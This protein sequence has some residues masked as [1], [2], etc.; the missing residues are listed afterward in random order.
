MKGKHPINKTSVGF[1]LWNQTHKNTKDLKIK[2]I[3]TGPEIT[4]LR[5]KLKEKLKE[6]PSH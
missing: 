1:L 3:I 2:N 4:F 5:F 6:K